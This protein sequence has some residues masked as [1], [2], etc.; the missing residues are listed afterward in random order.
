MPVW[1]GIV[2]ED[3]L[4]VYRRAGWGH[5][6]GF[7]KRPALLIIDV[8]YNFTGPEP[9]SL[10]DSIGDS[11]RSC[12]EASWDSVAA[13]KELKS[14]CESVAVPVLYTVGVGSKTLPV[15]QGRWAEK[16]PHLQGA[17]PF[18]EQT[19]LRGNEVVAPISPGP[20]S[21]VIPKMKPSAFF[22]TPL[23][24]YLTYF[25][26]DSLIIVGTTT[27][28]CIRASVIDAFSYN[29]KVAVVE[30]GTFDRGSVSHA[31]NLFDIHQKYGDV[32]S[33]DSAL[34]YLDGLA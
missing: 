10:L 16:N 15:E 25:G 18:E 28:G 34:Q 13:I 9:R 30:E 6:M 14:K 8:T 11:H 2:P 33:L 26:I 4:E 27:S 7:G 5:T 29:Y 17:E 23:Q 12:G 24:S 22:G 32:V 31:V 3:D 20:K 21:L 1:D 19:G